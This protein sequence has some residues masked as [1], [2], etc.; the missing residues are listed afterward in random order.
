VGV[1]TIGGVEIAVAAAAV[2]RGD[3]EEGARAALKEASDE[4]GESGLGELLSV[5]AIR[6]PGNTSVG[7]KGTVAVPVVVVVGNDRVG[8]I[9]DESRGP[10]PAEALIETP[11]PTEER[12]LHATK[13]CVKKSSASSAPP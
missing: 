7:I 4:D 1:E 8:R 12:S 6:G 9:V 2:A 11:A 10:D 13:A 5:D 3:L